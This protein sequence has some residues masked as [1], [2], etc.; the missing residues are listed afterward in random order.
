MKNVE[1]IETGETT[2][3]DILEK[4]MEISQIESEKYLGQILSSYGSNKL[5]IERN[6][7]QRNWFSLQN[8]NHTKKRIH[9]FK[10]SV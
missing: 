1:N 6:L 2:R 10:Y 3:R 7:N 5:Y 4:D 9:N 8:N